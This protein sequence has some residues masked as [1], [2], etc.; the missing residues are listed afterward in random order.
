MN[1]MKAYKIVDGTTGMKRQGVK[2]IRVFHGPLKLLPAAE[3]RVTTPPPRN[4][5]I[6]IVMEG[7]QSEELQ[8]RSQ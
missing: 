8:V 6:L 1:D 7:C 4:I 5:S 2:N 3:V